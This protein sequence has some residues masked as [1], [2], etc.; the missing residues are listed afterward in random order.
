MDNNTWH[1]NFN[2]KKFL[3][4]INV[5]SL[6]TKN[7][8]F[9]ESFINNANLDC[10]FCNKK[11]SKG[12]V[13]NNKSFLCEYCYLTI[14]S[15]S[16][17]EKY[18]KRYRDFLKEKE[19]YIEALQSFE[20][21]MGYKP[22]DSFIWIASCLITLFFSIILPPLF[23]ISIILGCFY[24]YIENQNK[25]SSNE[26]KKAKSEW[27]ALNRKP[28]T[29]ELRHFHDPLAELTTKD[30]LIL[31]IFN[32]WP[33]YPPFWKYL[34]E[35][36]LKKDNEHCQVTGCISRLSLHI[37]HIVPVSQSG[38]HTPDN[39]VTL[40]EFHHALEPDKGHERVW[41]N[42]KTKYFTLV[43]EHIRSGGKVKAHIR[44]L[45][46]IKLDDLKVITAFYGLCCSQCSNKKIKITLFSGKNIIRV[47]CNKCG[48]SINV[49][50]Q[51]AEETGPVLAKK[52]KVTRNNG[53]WKLRLDMLEQRHNTKWEEINKSEVKE[54]RRRHRD[55]VVQK[56]K[57]PLCPICGYPM[58]LII[59]SKNKRWKKFWG[60]TKYTTEGCR[61]SRSFD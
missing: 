8:V 39:L 32:H 59:P 10:I 46:L 43:Q 60:C 6:I 33:G 42:I 22:K 12:I 53:R 47:N 13:L 11:S 9:N 41:G 26:W 31:H 58:K 17:P 30:R 20:R 50:Q 4:K 16:F 24:L 14:S 45:E 57:I 15:I 2:P 37:H 34:R 56:D 48:W 40:C 49:N 61:G 5:E 52:M 23:V 21:E 3:G 25:Q 28:S 29:P 54:K 19:A 35:V 55:S 27:I 1:N 44:R 38:T 18:E 51:L 7:E 36:V